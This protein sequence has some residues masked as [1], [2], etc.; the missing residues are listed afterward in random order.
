MTVRIARL[1]A[2]IGAVMA[3]LALLVALLLS[4][5]K[6]SAQQ[7]ICMSLENLTSHLH[8]KQGE[9]IAWSGVTPLKDGGEVRIILFQS[10]R[11]TWTLAA[12]QGTQ[13][14]VIGIGL[15]ATPVV[16]GRDA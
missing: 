5:P 14:C 9:E 16:I 7:V 10:A 2:A 8:E 6:A 1:L 13:A 3:V 11:N 4:A 15:A 12:V